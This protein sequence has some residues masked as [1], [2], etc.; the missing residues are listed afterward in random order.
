[1]GG[2]AGQV[3]ADHQHD[4]GDAQDV[5]EQHAGARHFGEDAELSVSAVGDD[6]LNVTFEQASLEVDLREPAAQGVHFDP[7]RLAATSCIQSGEGAV[8][9]P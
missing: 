9:V 7:V 8:R 5:H 2:H 1:M 3:E 4:Q 6:E